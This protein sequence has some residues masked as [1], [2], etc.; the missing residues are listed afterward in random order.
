MVFKHAKLH[1]LY[2]VQ[3]Y[4]A[5][6]WKKK[7]NYPNYA[8]FYADDIPSE[9]QVSIGWCHPRRIVA[10]CENCFCHNL[11]INKVKFIKV[12][13]SRMGISWGIYLNSQI[14]TKKANKKKN[15][16]FTKISVFWAKNAKIFK[17][18]KL[19]KKVR[20]LSLDTCI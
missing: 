6:S 20:K 2:C 3:I 16:F 10:F 11:K 19:I 12:Y 1:T 17:N 5:W 18:K 14:L 4:N 15:H 7:K 8:F 13:I 9:L